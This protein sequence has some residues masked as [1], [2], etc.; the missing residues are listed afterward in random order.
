MERAAKMV[1]KFFLLRKSVNDMIDLMKPTMHIPFYKT[2]ATTILKKR[3]AKGRHILLLRAGKFT[4]I[5]FKV[6]KA[7]SSKNVDSPAKSRIKLFAMR[8]LN[9]ILFFF[10]V[11]QLIGI[12]VNTILMRY[13]LN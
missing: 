6:S 5:V 4:E 11:S 1:K 9:K 8:K 13:V 7:N 3:D 10:S 2:E 12:P